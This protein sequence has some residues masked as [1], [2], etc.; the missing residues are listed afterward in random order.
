M[1]PPPPLPVDEYDDVHEH[2]ARQLGHGSMA[3]SELGAAD[4]ER[5][6]WI[7]CVC[8]HET[9][10]YVTPSSQLA[11]PTAVEHEYAKHVIDA[12]KLRKPWVKRPAAHP[13]SKP[14]TERAL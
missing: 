6:H 11:A 7:E 9:R 2:A 1:M 8:G 4:T 12:L 13:F 3:W 14:N 10:T 5:V